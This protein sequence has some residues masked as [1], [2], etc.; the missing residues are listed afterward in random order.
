[1]VINLSCIKS[2][3]YWINLS[4]FT[5][6]PILMKIILSLNSATLPSTKDQFYQ[7]EIY[8]QYKRYVKS[9]Q[10]ITNTVKTNQIFIFSFNIKY[11]I[12]FPSLLKY[13]KRF[14]NFQEGINYPCLWINKRVSN[15]NQ[16]LSISLIY[17]SLYCMACNN[18]TAFRVYF[19]SRLPFLS[20]I[21][22][23]G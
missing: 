17:S 13:N 14:S 22:I 10:N 2:L 23:F 16:L 11:R 8:P 15:S 20:L 1:M 18:R 5:V 9:L 21:N 7:H 19:I 12:I 4:W 6:R 3:I